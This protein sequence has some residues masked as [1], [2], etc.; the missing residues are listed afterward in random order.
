MKRV[1][2]A[3]LLLS[4]PLYGDGG[5]VLSRGESGPFAI[6]VFAAPSD[7]TALVQLRDTLA[8]VLDAQVVFTVASGGRELRFSANHADAQNKLLYGAPVTFPNPGDWSY[9][10]TVNGTAQLAGVYRADAPQLR[11]AQYWFYFAL[12]PAIVFIFLLHHGLAAEGRRRRPGQ[13]FYK[14]L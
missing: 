10:V 5:A 11:A 4:A 14:T 8:P 3:G 1:L 7:W 12:P 13:A 9:K 2:I 6:T